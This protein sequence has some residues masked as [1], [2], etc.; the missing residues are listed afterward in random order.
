M[1]SLSLQRVASS[2]AA[3]FGG[4]RMVFIF[5]ALALSLTGC[6]GGTEGPPR[7]PVAGTVTL[8][9]QPLANAEVSLYADGEARV[10]TTD[11]DGFYQIT[12]GA[13]VLKYTVV[14]SKFEGGG[15]IAL[16]AAAGMDSG[17]LQAM[18]MADGSG[19]TAAKIAKQLVPEKFSSREKSELSV[20]V[21]LEGTQKADFTLVSK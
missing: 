19:K 16:D 12:G 17:Q 3:F 20:V 9:G 1:S 21:P 7:V 10:A 6:G 13:Q 4:V 2:A 14:V 8:D 15:A 5:F 18:Q 11:K